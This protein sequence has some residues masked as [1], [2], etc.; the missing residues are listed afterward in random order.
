ML[1]QPNAVFDERITA[2]ARDA[3]KAGV[4]AFSERIFYISGIGVH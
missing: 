4:Q 1:L 3:V 2:G